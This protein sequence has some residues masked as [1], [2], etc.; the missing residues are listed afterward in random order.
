[1]AEALAPDW[2]VPVEQR[3]TDIV[4]RAARIGR[5]LAPPVWHGAQVFWELRERIEDFA[6]LSPPYRLGPPVSFLAIEA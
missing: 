6:R 2:A 5:H 1:M 4:L 3:N